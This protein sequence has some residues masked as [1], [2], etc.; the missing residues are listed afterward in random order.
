MDT[1]ISVWLWTASQNVEV[2][3]RE[4]TEST[5]VFEGT[6]AKPNEKKWCITELE[7]LAVVEAM[8]RDNLFQVDI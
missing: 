7:G 5:I 1:G 8:I 4:T 2:F 3:P 6:S